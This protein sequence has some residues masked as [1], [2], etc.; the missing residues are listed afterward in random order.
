MAI[1]K[2]LAGASLVLLALAAAPVAQAQNAGD[3]TTNVTRPHKVVDPAKKAARQAK[4][5]HRREMQRQMQQQQGS[6]PT[7]TSGPASN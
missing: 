5:K 6:T 7:M 3:G 1:T 4:R 2:I